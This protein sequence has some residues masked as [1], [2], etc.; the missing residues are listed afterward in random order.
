MS[1]G[2]E[3]HSPGFTGAGGGC[4][5]FCKTNANEASIRESFLR[6]MMLMDRAG[7]NRFPA[8]SAL[9]SNEAACHVHKGLKQ[10]LRV[11]LI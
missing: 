7:W 4:L 3:R 8:F 6:Q 5:K 10:D 11:S 9:N 1:D 2:P